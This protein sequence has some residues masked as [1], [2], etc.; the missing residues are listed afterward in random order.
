MN[1]Y[2]IVL[3]LAL[4]LSYAVS[5]RINQGSGFLQQPE[6]SAKGY[7]GTFTCKSEFVKTPSTKGSSSK[8][9][10]LPTGKPN[11]FLQQYI[12]FAKEALKSCSLKSESEFTGQSVVGFTDPESKAQFVGYKMAED[13]ADSWYIEFTKGDQAGCLQYYETQTTTGSDGK[14]KTETYEREACWNTA[15]YCKNLLALVTSTDKETTVLRNSLKVATVQA[16]GRGECKF[17]YPS[18]KG[19]SSGFSGSINVYN[20]SGHFLI[21]FPDSRYFGRTR[22]ERYEITNFK[23]A[24]KRGEELSSF[25]GAIPSKPAK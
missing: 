8:P 18:A 25:A 11:C 24:V 4:C 1:K 9:E 14:P 21:Y 23:V 5:I 16:A 22:D 2:T 3:V 10:Q 15:D 13:S 19:A 12:T 6:C 17:Q 7:S 20:G